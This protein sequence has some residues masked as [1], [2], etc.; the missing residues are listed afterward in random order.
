MFQAFCSQVF[1]VQSPITFA[2]TSQSEQHRALGSLEADL[3]T[4]YYSN[5]VPRREGFLCITTSIFFLLPHVTFV[6]YSH[7]SSFS[8]SLLPY[9]LTPPSLSSYT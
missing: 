2:L 4:G 8:P 9:L 1:I 5:Q 7:S 6:Q 3:D